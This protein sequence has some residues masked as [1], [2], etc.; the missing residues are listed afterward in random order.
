MED[1]DN[2]SQPPPDWWQSVGLR[3]SGAGP[4]GLQ[5]R[6]YTGAMLTYKN[7][8]FWLTAGRAIDEIRQAIYTA[9]FTNPKLSWVIGFNV[10]GVGTIPVHDRN[11]YMESWYSN[12]LDFGIV[13]P[14]LQDEAEIMSTNLIK[15]LNET[16]T[17][18]FNEISP[19]GYILAGFP[20]I[21]SNVS[22]KNLA[23]V[24]VG[25]GTE[26]KLL[27]YPIRRIPWQHLPAPDDFWK[28]PSAFYGELIP[29][30]DFP[31]RNP[32][33]IDSMNG[34]PVFSVEIN[35]KGK[36]DYRLIGVQSG[37][38]GEFKVRCFPI[39]KILKAIDEW[40]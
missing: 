32:N 17:A 26:S 14:G 40:A 6:I 36:V 18:A 13:I 35:Q 5:S 39:Q 21:L 8:H 20:K 23:L 27:G 24:P 30:P 10:P 15:S 34:S 29:Y 3:I 12:G 16:S 2:R 1:T 11:L 19:Q 33:E 4:L 28:D 37:W 22:T 9:K 38:D 7:H 31:D 25:S